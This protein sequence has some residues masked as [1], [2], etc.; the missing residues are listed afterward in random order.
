MAYQRCGRRPLRIELH[1]AP[2]LL[3]G[4]GPIP[5]P[6]QQRE[7]Q[8]GV[9]GRQALVQLQ[10]A[11][12]RLPGAGIVVE[13]GARLGQA[14]IGRGERG[15]GVDGPLEV[16]DR[17]LKVVG[18]PAGQVLLALRVGFRGWRGRRLGGRRGDRRRNLEPGD[19]QCTSG[20]D[21]KF[22]HLPSSIARY[23]PSGFDH[24]QA[25]QGV[26]RNSIV[27]SSPT[28]LPPSGEKACSQ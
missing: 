15:V 28:W 7:A 2:E 21:G 16:L 27:H 22:S 23:A 5:V 8:D 10:R 1:G 26:R 6:V 19:Q 14:R 24:G 25:D 3:F 13:Q 18:G 11:E 12:R 9:R 17:R 4:A 20:E